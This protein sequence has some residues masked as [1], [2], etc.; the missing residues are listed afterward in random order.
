MAK[1]TTITNPLTGQPVQ[2]DQLE[3]TAQ[4][5]DDGIDAAGI[6]SIDYPGCYYRMVGSVVEWANPPMLLGV[7][8]RTTERYLGKPVYVRLHDFGA[9]PNNTVKEDH[10]P[11][12]WSIDKAICAYGTTSTGITIPTQNYAGPITTGRHISMYFMRTEVTIATD[13]NFTSV[14]ATLFLKYTKT[15]D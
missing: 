2:V 11:E 1:I 13:G 6:E 12:S 7:E 14:S 15:T 4:Q 9:L 8:Y 3:H 5:I 10:S